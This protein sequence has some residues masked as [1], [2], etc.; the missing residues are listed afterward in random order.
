M[1]STPSC[2]LVVCALAAASPA[3]AQVQERS[4]KTLELTLSEALERARQ[5]SPRVQLARVRLQLARG[6]LVGA[7]TR[8]AANPSVN[9]SV[10][11]RFEAEETLPNVNVNVRQRFE[12][13]GQR[14]A[15]IEA[16]EAGIE[17][18]ELRAQDAARLSQREVAAAF[19]RARH[20]EERV[21]IARDAEALAEAIQRV[22]RRREEAGQAGG[23]DERLAALAYARARMERERAAVLRDQRL[24]ELHGLLG[25]E[26][27]VELSVRGP[28][29]D[30]SRHELERL[31]ER[32][33]ARADLQALEAQRRRAGAQARLGRAE[34]WPDLRLGLGYMREERA[35]VFM[36]MFTVTL[37]VFVYGQGIEA[38]AQ[39][40]QE[41]LRRERA[42]T[43]RAIRVEVRDA[44][45]AYQR[46]LEATRRYEEEALPL[47]QESLELAQKSYEAGAMAL[48]ELLAI[49]RELVE[50]RQAHAE[51]LLVTALAGVE[52]EATAGVLR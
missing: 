26:P 41:L 24:A 32:A 5:S 6:Q 43:E 35:D 48:A 10:G 1:R 31:L 15:R 18:D 29:L 44:F 14:R 52:L 12:L 25:L 20:A 27:E 8:L 37:P 33:P 9:L 17:R 39:A 2:L 4:S 50:A 16:A 49:R 38:T 22:A 19:L 42:L 3:P 40:R 51:L 21:W 34:A 30:R 11:P 45:G 23:L 28:L 36:G 46:L 7:S 13:G 47:V